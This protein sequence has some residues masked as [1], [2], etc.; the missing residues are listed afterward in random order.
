M[1]NAEKSFPVKNACQMGTEVTQT[2]KKKTASAILKSKI[3]RIFQVRNACFYQYH[4][5]FYCI[6]NYSVR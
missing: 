3:L 2:V 4:L 5:T 1:L 6:S